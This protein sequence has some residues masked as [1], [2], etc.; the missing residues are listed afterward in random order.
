MFQ[1]STEVP[2][3]HSI[4]LDANGVPSSYAIDNVSAVMGHPGSGGRCTQPQ[5]RSSRKSGPLCL[6]SLCRSLPNFCRPLARRPNSSQ[7]E[8]RGDNHRLELREAMAGEARQLRK[9]SGGTLCTIPVASFSATIS[10]TMWLTA[11]KESYSRRTTE[12][13]L[14]HP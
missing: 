12:G 14:Q 11:R 5:F 10:W 9:N 8:R 13:F 4:K 3:F 6:V 2:C 7:G 1:R